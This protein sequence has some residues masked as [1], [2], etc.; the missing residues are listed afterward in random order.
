MGQEGGWTSGSDCAPL[1]APVPGRAA[2]ARGR[3]P[4][5]GHLGSLRRPLVFLSMTLFGG[6]L[7]SYIGGEASGCPG[8][9]AWPRG[10]SRGRVPLPQ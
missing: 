1:I 6:D 3:H 10:G 2:C 9:V 8:S 7:K 5:S 4:A